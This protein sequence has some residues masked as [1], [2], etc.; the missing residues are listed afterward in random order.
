MTGGRGGGELE[1]A[2][3]QELQREGQP[4]KKR[5]LVFEETEETLQPDMGNSNYVGKSD[6]SIIAM[7]VSEH[8]SRKRRRSD[9]YSVVEDDKS[10]ITTTERTRVRWSVHEAGIHWIGKLVESWMGRQ[11]TS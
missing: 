1:A 4:Y 8:I 10:P 9:D 7:V 2:K 5:S 3:L 11:M 6:E